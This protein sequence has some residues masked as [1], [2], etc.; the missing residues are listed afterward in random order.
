MNV[1]VIDQNGQPSQSALAEEKKQT[2]D[3]RLE[4]LRE[5][6]NTSRA[7]GELRVEFERLRDDMNDRF[8]R[9]EA[10]IKLKK[11]GAA[12]GQGF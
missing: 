10:A 11:R 3:M 2:R 9:L 4:M 7:V 6:A 5:F 8:D 1:Q 12:A